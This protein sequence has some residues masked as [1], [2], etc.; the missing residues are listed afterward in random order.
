MRGV[1]CNRFC[2]PPGLAVE[3]MTPAQPAGH[4]GVV[5]FYADGNWVE[6]PQ[7]DTQ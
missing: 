2:P 3:E 5:R 6:P 7:G 4:E 1:R